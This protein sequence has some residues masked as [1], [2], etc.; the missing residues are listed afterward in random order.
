MSRRILGCICFCLFFDVAFAS[1]QSVTDRYTPVTEDMLVAAPPGDW[2]MWRRT[3]SHWGHSPLDQI[4]TSN[5]GKLRLAWA[6]TMETGMQET[7]PLVHDGIMFLVQAC[8]FVEALDVRDGSRLWQY[9]RPQVEHG[10]FMA[11][12][13]RNGALYG[14]KLI[15]GT[16]DAHLVALNARTGEV[17]WEEQVGDWTIGHH[18]SGGPATTP[19]V[20]SQTRCGVGARPG[21][22]PATTL[23]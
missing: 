5:V 2:L 22:R 21:T 20:T 16:H 13:N 15:I 18:Y 23:S 11:C 3:Y 4:D 9:R 12:A 10:A 1:A 19:G 14:D 7:T 17:E 8:D 6:W